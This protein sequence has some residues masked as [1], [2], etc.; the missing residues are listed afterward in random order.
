MNLGGAPAGTRSLVEKLGVTG[1]VARGAE[2]ALAGVF[3]II[4]AAR[5][6]Q[7]K[8]EGKGPP[9][10]DPGTCSLSRLGPSM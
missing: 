10:G 3:L 8:A 7:S 6:S 9:S 5:F 4:A 1:E 2:T